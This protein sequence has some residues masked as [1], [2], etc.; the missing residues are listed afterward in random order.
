M[1]EDSTVG[2]MGVDMMESI[3]LIKNMALGHILGQMVGSILENGLI[4]NVTA[5]EKSS[6]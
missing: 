4:A 5:G 2:V 6:Q 3:N 1:E